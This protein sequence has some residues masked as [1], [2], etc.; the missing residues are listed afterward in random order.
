MAISNRW[1]QISFA[2]GCVLRPTQGC[3]W[4]VFATRPF[5]AG[6]TVLEGSSVQRVARNDSH[7]VQLGREEFG[8]EDGIGSFVNHSCDPNCVVRPSRVQRLDLVA[9]RPI[10]N[11]EQITL[12]YAT[13]NYVIEFF[14]KFCRCGAPSCRGSVTG[15]RDLPNTHRLTYRDAIAPYLLELD[16]RF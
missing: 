9:R 6:E 13:R 5:V 2:P 12:D 8:H 16:G 10:L 3:G 15:W 14:P 7:A 4:G 1:G 11:A